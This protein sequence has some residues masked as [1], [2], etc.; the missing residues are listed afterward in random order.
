MSNIVKDIYLTTD[1]LNFLTNANNLTK[2]VSKLE[3]FTESDE[4]INK[5]KFENF[6]STNETEE[7]KKKRICNLVVYLRCAFTLVLAIALLIANLNGI[8]SD[9]MFMGLLLL[10]LF[11]PDF[12]LLFLI[13][14]AVVNQTDKGT[15]TNNSEPELN[16]GTNQEIEQDTGSMANLKYSLTSTPDV[17]N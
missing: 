3:K 8:M 4:K 6:T 1:K 12:T 16:Q 7:E 11:M 17:F 10:S 2:L 9:E 13:I 14:I 15:S 5:K